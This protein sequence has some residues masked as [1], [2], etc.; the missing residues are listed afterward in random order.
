[1]SLLIACEYSGRV[2]DAFHEKGYE[3][4]SCDLLPSETSGEHYQGN[5]LDLLGLSKP[6]K[7]SASTPQ[8]I[9]RKFNSMIAFPPCTYLCNS[10]VRWL[11]NED[12]SRNKERWSLMEQGARFFKSLWE[13]PIPHICIENPVMHKYAKE[14][15]FGNTG[16]NYSQIIHPWM[17]GH[18][19]KKATC[20]FLK[21]LPPLAETNNVKKETDALP[22]KDQQK[23]H[24]MSPGPARWRERSRTYAGIARAM[25]DQWQG[26][27]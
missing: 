9:P 1:M 4:I 3:A 27:I 16:K 18:T 15:I 23:I 11:F 10:G 6:R 26:I 2:R 25:A 24:Y 13:A 21:G 12:G 22:I 8:V 14:I 5:V 20:L 19:E 7:Y 17:F